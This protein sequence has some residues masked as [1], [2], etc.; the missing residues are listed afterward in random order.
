MSNDKAALS[1]L[2]SVIQSSKNLKKLHVCVDVHGCVRHNYGTDFSENGERFP[3]LEE[4]ALEWFQI[5]QRCGEYWLKAMD[6]SRL[7]ALD[8][9]E[10]SFSDSFLPLLLPITDKLP[11]LESIGLNLPPWGEEDVREQR[12][13]PNSPFSLT[14]QLFL[15]ARPQSL[16]DVRV[17]GHYRPL[18]PDILDHHAASLKY[19]SLHE[20]EVASEDNQRSP[21]SVEE[22]EEIGTKSTGLEALAFDVNISKRHTWVGTYPGFYSTVLI[23]HCPSRTI[24]STL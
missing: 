8:F 6:W 21:I 22:L 16:V 24:S 3:P 1:N 18:L 14:R 2:Q 10:G 23:L 5:T 17:Q 19:L 4:L 7:R 9:R 12:N 11:A 20:T 13:D 15:T